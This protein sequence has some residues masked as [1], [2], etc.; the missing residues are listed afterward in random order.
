[1]LQPPS[2]PR[3][4]EDSAFKKHWPLVWLTLLTSV[5]VTSFVLDFNNLGKIFDN[6]GT[7]HWRYETNYVFN[8]SK[9][10]YSYVNSINVG[11]KDRKAD[12]K[13]I[14][15]WQSVAD[16]FANLVANRSVPYD[17][18]Q[19]ENYASDRQD[20]RQFVKWQFHRR[21]AL[22]FTQRQD[23]SAAESEF[24]SALT[25]AQN[26]GS[27]YPFQAISLG[28]L[29]LYN[30]LRAE[31]MQEVSQILL[32]AVLPI[33][34]FL[35]ALLPFA[36]FLS[37]M[38]S[39]DKAESNGGESRN[40]LA[41]LFIKTMLLASW[42]GVVVTGWVALRNYGM[43]LAYGLTDPAAQAFFASFGALLVSCCLMLR[44][45][46]PV[47][48]LSLKRSLVEFGFGGILLVAKAAA[49]Y[50]GLCLS[51]AGH[52]ALKN[53]LFCESLYVAKAEQAQQLAIQAKASAE[54]TMAELPFLQDQLLRD[55]NGVLLRKQSTD[56]EKGR[57]KQLLADLSGRMEND[58]SL[59]DNKVL[60]F[61][62]STK[63]EDRLGT[64]AAYTPI[65]SRN[66]TIG[67]TLK[68]CLAYLLFFY[69]ECLAYI[70]LGLKQT[71]MALSTFNR[72]VRVKEYFLG[73]EH[74]LVVGMLEM[75][76]SCL[77]SFHRT[78]ELRLLGED[79]LRK[80]ISLYEK[81][82]GRHDELTIAAKM[83][84]AHFHSQRG[85][86]K[87]AEKILLEALRDVGKD[88]DTL[89]YCGL[90]SVIGRL[91]YRR[92]DYSRAKQMYKQ[93]I[94]LLEQKISKSPPCRGWF[95]YLRNIYA[96]TPTWQLE[97]KLVHAYLDLAEV[98][99]QAKYNGEAQRLTDDANKRIGAFESEVV[100]VMDLALAYVRARLAQAKI[101][102]EHGRYDECFKLLAASKKQINKWGY[103]R[104]I[105]GFE[106][107]V[108]E[109]EL[110][111]AASR[112][113]SNFYE[114]ARK[115]YMEGFMRFGSRFASA[116]IR[117]ECNLNQRWSSIAAQ[118]G[119]A[120]S[121][122]RGVDVCP[123]GISTDIALASTAN[124]QLSD[125][126]KAAGIWSNGL[127]SGDSWFAWTPAVVPVTSGTSYAPLSECP[128]TSPA[129]S[130][131][132][133]PSVP[134]S[135]PISVEPQDE[136]IVIRWKRERERE[137]L[138]DY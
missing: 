121:N 47:R 131:S 67:M 58:I 59:P 25:A 21:L 110:S 76:G 28:D 103:G 126:S 6:Q 115:N 80:A 1:M 88:M 72:A 5:F 136:G 39:R 112:G 66:L 113:F 81:S 41:R 20:I 46:P 71:N 122:V 7:D 55:M 63:V 133:A 101:L 9:F 61:I 99:S 138:F 57:T 69:P 40:A 68:A 54:S 22:E 108:G 43:G 65:N 123:A 48:S 15:D 2:A 120:K 38:K 89:A 18:V 56:I 13:R 19:I 130:V 12:A 62:F 128:A 111:L 132:G 74:W 16:S 60:P 78:D 27:A 116:S 36:L 124:R 82:R 95:G 14:K 107:T 94:E 73:A 129:A 119:Q 33:F 104:S 17:S 42:L 10:R 102:C 106:F 125:S 32:R 109:C 90:L 26:L 137:M 117:P 84:L 114:T 93:I 118:F 77:L 24:V 83:S 52:P 100:V 96:S 135:S 34:S 37:F 64:A 127:L 79:Y 50:V 11:K 23:Y 92:S 30:E 4:T 49:I 8:N 45:M 35:A 51:L 75:F 85:D 44:Y 91:Y 3:F 70:L 29:A 98:F 53:G 97:L 31:Q 105:V 134:A 87:Q 86:D